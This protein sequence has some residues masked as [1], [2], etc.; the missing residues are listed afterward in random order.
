MV[1]ASGVGTVQARRRNGKQHA[2]EPCRKAKIACDHSLPCCERCK[3]RKVTEK[4]VYLAA[5]M[6][7]PAGSGTA[8]PGSETG[9]K[10][11]RHPLPTPS[12]SAAPSIA[13]PPLSETHVSKEVRSPVSD[14][15]FIKSGGFFGPTNFSAV[16]LEN[17]DNL[18]SGNEEM[19]I[20]NDSEDPPPPSTSLQSQ[21]FLMLAGSGCECNPRVEL[22]AKVLMALPDKNTCNFL[23][24][25]YYEKCHECVFFKHTIV[26]CAK[27]L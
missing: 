10:E 24:E 9:R 14:G 7:R 25:W 15:P 4:C 2:C 5:P 21:T 17:R 11:Q 1:S 20:S 18:V 19:H 16:F 27:S 3:R 8:P 22:G 23:L 6:T 13:S 26:S 12:V